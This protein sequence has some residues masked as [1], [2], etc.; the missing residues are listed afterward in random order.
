[1]S[2]ARAVSLPKT[3]AGILL[4]RRTRDIIEVL[5]GHP[6]G[7]FWKKKDAGAWSIPKGLIAFGEEPLEA[8]QREFFEETGHRPR[9]AFIA[10]GASKQSGGKTVHVWASDDDWDP[11]KLKSNAFQMEWPPHSGE[12]QDF[13]ELD[14]ASWFAVHDA[15]D[16][17][18]KGQLVFLDRLED[19]LQ[20]STDQ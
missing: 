18:L 2:T 6:G 8:A 11:Q 17:I 10:L 5:L 16:R 4:F 19:A 3:S 15:R 14:R 12:Y 13:P 20:S 9:G 7:P 1:M